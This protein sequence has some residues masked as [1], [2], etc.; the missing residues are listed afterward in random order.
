MNRFLRLLVAL[1]PLCWTLIRASAQ[2]T[3]AFTFAAPLVASAMLQAIGG[4]T[5]YEGDFILEENREDGTSL[6][7]PVKLAAKGSKVYC[8][9]NIAGA[10]NVR[11]EASR[12]MLRNLGMDRMAMIHQIGEPTFIS[13]LPSL[14]AAV[15]MPVSEEI[16]KELQHTREVGPRIRNAGTEIVDGVE[17]KR[18][19]VPDSANQLDI[20]W[21]QTDRKDFPALFEGI[22]PGKSGR[23]VLRTVSLQ[24]TPPSDARFSLPPGIKKYDSLEE[25][26]KLTARRLGLPVPRPR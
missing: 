19:V 15:D 11:N 7:M 18:V 17:F 10:S 26:Q 8:E 24:R 13:I 12:L 4:G 1:V 2:D 23:I 21:L 16:T 20:A 25:I 22:L 14:K 3:N 5:D 6:T 9:L